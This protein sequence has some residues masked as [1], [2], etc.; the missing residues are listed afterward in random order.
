MKTYFVYRCSLPVKNKSYYY[1]TTISTHLEFQVAQ[2][3]TIKAF[4]NIVKDSLSPKEQQNT[5]YYYYSAEH[6]SRQ[7][8]TKLT[9]QS[10]TEMYASY[11]ENTE[12]S[13]IFLT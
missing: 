1:T 6:N 9:L 10:T 13:R 8:H 11:I 7:N 5:I 2:V 12:A 3:H 4:I